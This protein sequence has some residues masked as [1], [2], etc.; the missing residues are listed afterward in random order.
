MRSA[1]ASPGAACGTRLGGDLDGAHVVRTYARLCMAAVPAALVGGTVGFGILELVGTGA[2]GS[3]AALI[4]GG[5]LL[6]GI[7]FVAAKKMRIERSTAWSAW[8]V[9]GSDAE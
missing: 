4:C 7:F 1:S 2:F 3:L 9:D 5:V 8:F 6:L